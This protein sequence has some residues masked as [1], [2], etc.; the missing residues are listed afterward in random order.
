[1]VSQTGLDPF[2]HLPD[3]RRVPP[4]GINLGQLGF[5]E[6]S[7][8]IAAVT[9]L[10]R[11]FDVKC[12]VVSLDAIGCQ[13]KTTVVIPDAGADWLPVGARTLRY[14]GPLPLGDG[15]DDRRGPVVVL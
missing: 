2:R 3:S 6:K 7:D 5:G 8:V 4:R 13:H 14:S 1:M 11:Q 9:K 10:P 15:Y 12:C